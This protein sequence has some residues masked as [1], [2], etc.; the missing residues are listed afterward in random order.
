MYSFN[1]TPHVHRI[2]VSELHSIISDIEDVHGRL[3]RLAEDANTDSGMHQHS[4]RMMNERCIIPFHPQ[5]HQYVSSWPHARM[6]EPYAGR[7]HENPYPRP[8]ASGSCPLPLS[9]NYAPNCN[10]NMSM[11]EKKRKREDTES[12]EDFHAK[13]LRRGGHGTGQVW[14]S[15][16]CRMC[17]G[18]RRRG[19]IEGGEGG[20]GGEVGIEMEAGA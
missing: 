20:R 10:T 13:S 17:G 8:T 16:G 11:N 6:R 4:I 1:N 15:M 19:E 12:E 2:S 7:S 5:A 9:P 18:R 14:E 3:R